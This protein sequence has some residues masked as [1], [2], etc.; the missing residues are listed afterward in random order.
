[1]IEPK[2]TELSVRAERAILVR[3]LLPGDNN[4]EEYPL[5]ELAM[6]AKTAG[7]RVIENIVQKRNKIDG[8]YYLGKGKAMELASLCASMGADVI[9]CDDDLSPSQVQNLEEITD[10]KVIDRSELIL[11]IFAT[12]ART[13]QAQLQVELAQMEYTLPRLKHMW[14]HLER[15]EGGIGTR[16][17]GEKQLEIDKRLASKKIIDLKKKLRDIE[18]I[19]R[20]Q[21]ESRNDF[22]TISLVGYTNAGKSTL[23]NAL[24]NAGVYVEDKLFATL[25]TTTR[26]LN[27]DKG[28][29]ILLSDTVGFIRKLP[30]HLVS[31]FQATLEETRHADLLLHVVDISSQA[32]FEQIGAVNEVLK[33]IGCNEKPTIMVLNKSDLLRDASPIMIIKKIFKDCVAISAYSGE[34]LDDLKKMIVSHFDKGYEETWFICDNKEGR[35]IAYIFENIKVLDRYQNGDAM[36]FLLMINKQ[37]LARLYKLRSC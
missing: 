15:I 11:D 19:K 20:Q 16:G 27:L 22:M 7:A 14:S 23:M 30:H 37:Q 18:Q 36:H 28:K 9:I 24:T 21:V 25:D 8:V 3:V 4:N 35:L 34:G 6:L 26:S 10:T 17:P 13:K 29:S 33:K 5:S 31:S 1:M 12:H 2:R 32:V